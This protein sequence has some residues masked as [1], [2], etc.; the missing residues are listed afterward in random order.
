MNKKYFETKS[1][2]LE[3]ISTKIATEQP[4]ITKE[5][6]K[7]KLERKTYLENKPGS[8]EDAA[9]KVV[10][11]GKELEE[12]LDE[13]SPTIAKVKD[14]VKNKQAIK[15]DGTTVDLF[16]ASAISQ[17]YDKVNDV[18]KKKMDGMKI[19]PLAN[20]A[21]KLLKNEYEH[22][23]LEEEISESPF[24]VSYSGT[25]TSDRKQ[26]GANIITQKTGTIK[27]DA[28][29]E[30]SAKK[31]VSKILDKRMNLRRYDI[32]RVRAEDFKTFREGLQPGFAVRYLDPKNGKRFAVA[33]KIKKD[34]DDK[35]A[36]LKKDG[37]KDISITK[38]T[39]N[40]KE[41]REIAE[42][43][44]GHTLSFLK[45]KGFNV[46]RFSYGKLLVP[47]SDVEDVK[48]LLKKET[49]KVNGDVTVMPNAIIGE[50]KEEVLDEGLQLSKLVGK[51]IA[52]LEMYVELANDIKKEYFKTNSQVSMFIKAKADQVLRS[53]PSLV[54]DLRKPGIWS[55]QVELDEVNELCQ[56]GD[57]VKKEETMLEFTTQ[58]IKQ[59]YG[60]LNDPRYKQG[61]YSG[62]VKAIEK[63]AK[64]LSKHKDVA[65]ALKRANESVIVDPKAKKET[66]KE[67]CNQNKKSFEKLRNETKLV[68]LGD[69]GKT[70]TGQK[71]AVIDLEPRAIP[72]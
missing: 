23:E 65:N 57:K 69:K 51:S 24:A 31:L 37:A 64:G 7:I 13:A 48:K 70:A 49:E 50:A 21:M 8:L 66:K 29:D 15:I 9:A 25:K 53:V 40:F 72:V 11:E 28:K 62:A 67:N 1:G 46:A 27:V 10:S 36:Q 47:K 17:V 58:Q 16:T 33:Y 38:H 63:L 26:R 35:A 18:N 30:D 4:T 71:A 42:G 6:P 52:H 55:E 43:F 22:T 39:I 60:I 44:E 34:A 61:N 45:R 68:R 19:I 20:I 32:D 59:A 56:V 54:K 12:V 14:I 2:S 5:E 41:D 3:E